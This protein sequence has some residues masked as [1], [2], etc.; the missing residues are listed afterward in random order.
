MGSGDTNRPEVGSYSLS[1]VVKKPNSEECTPYSPTKPIGPF[2]VTGE[3]VLSPNG[4]YPLEFQ[5]VFDEA[6]LMIEK[7]TEHEIEIFGGFGANTGIE[8][9]NED[10][11]VVAKPEINAKKETKSQSSL[12]DF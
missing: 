3:N 2:V 12:F 7:D 11:D 5:K 4:V 10:D 6:Q 8:D 1:R 9:E